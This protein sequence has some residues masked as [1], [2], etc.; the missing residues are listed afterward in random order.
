MK[1]AIA[2]LVATGGLGLTALLLQVPAMA[3]G[4]CHYDKPE[5]AHG[6]TVEIKGA[7]FHAT[8][9]HVKV[10]D[11]V[12]WVNSEDMTHTVTGVAGSFGDTRDLRMG[13]HVSYT[14][15][16]NGVYPYFCIYH[17]AM[18]G[19]IVAGDGGGVGAASTTRDAEPLAVV[20]KGSLPQGAPT[21]VANRQVAAV[22]EVVPSGYYWAAGFVAV[23]AGAA[24]FIAGRRRRAS[25]SRSL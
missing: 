11:T 14:F 3:G 22:K 12:T 16:K 8:V 25:A 6:T 10:G 2:M 1:R 7:C 9:T 5:D 17:P 21:P 24:G 4:G 13:H 15:R 18:V 19:A 20:L 23:L